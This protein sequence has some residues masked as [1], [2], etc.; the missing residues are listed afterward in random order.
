M[1]PELIETI[2]VDAEQR[3]PLL[4]RHLQRLEASCKAPVSYTHLTL[5]TTPYV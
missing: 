3:V 5:P 4:T 2:L 1:Q